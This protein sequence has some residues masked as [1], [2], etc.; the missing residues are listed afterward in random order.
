MKTRHVAFR[1]S[2]G[3]GRL[4]L[5]GA[6]A[7]LAALLAL[8]PVLAEAQS[9]PRDLVTQAQ[10]LRDAGRFADAVGV[11]RTALAAHPDDSEAARL[12]AQTLYW[13]KDVTASLAAYRAALTRHPDDST[14]RL[15]FARTLAETGDRPQARALAQPLQANP[16]TRV[17]ADALLGT[18]EYWD[19]D[20]TT[21]ARLFREVL[22]LNPAHGD[23]QLQLRAIQAGSA[24][25][26]RLSST[27]AHDD[28]PLTRLRGGGE[29]GWWLTPLAPVSMRFEPTEYQLPNGVTRR[30]WSAD[31]S[32]SDYLPSAHLEAEVAA[33]LLQQGN[34]GRVD[35]HGRAVAGL[36]VTP[37]LTV[38]ARAERTVY[39]ST[40]T[41]IDSPIVVQSTTVLAHWDARGWLGEAAL[42]RQ[43]FPDANAIDTSYAW[44][45]AP[46]VHRP[47][48]EFQV[49]YAFSRGNADES[50]FALANPSQP[51]QPSDS[52]F[53]VAGHY[54]PYYTPAHLM[55]HAAIG[56]IAF[57]PSP[58]LTLR[59]SG[60]APIR[61]TD[62]APVFLIVASQALRTTYA[63]RFSPWNA[64]ASTE[65]SRR[66]GMTFTL[67]GE[68]GRSIFYSW[69]TAD[70]ALTYRF[71]GRRSMPAAAPR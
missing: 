14:T 3:R 4:G 60:S 38:R 13:M 1:S 66:G 2:S 8:T 29:A 28:Q 44:L 47:D 20:L 70:V 34:G 41:S 62:D 55:S 12:L 67:G 58:A 46:L 48:G 69:A 6:T 23:A 61:A 36:R 51:Y 26:I 56:A 32:V 65:F 5:S 18:L 27:L 63:R 57:R 43:R 7:A 21:A 64:R 71:S 10:Q 49:G 16:V 52:R 30:M 24:P 39:L 22:R 25:W 17:D 54:V 37:S 15:Q 68:I 53:N 42:Q 19:G 9:Q 50:R 35:W 45:L 33:G 59:F 11:L 40:L 31:A